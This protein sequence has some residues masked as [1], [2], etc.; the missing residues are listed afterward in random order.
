VNSQ[1]PTIQL[2][3][4]WG[5]ILALVVFCLPVEA[6]RTK[7]SRQA[8]H[9]IFLPLVQWPPLLPHSLYYINSGQIYRMERDGITITQ[10]TF[11]P[12]SVFD[13][14]ISPLTGKMA[15]SS[16]NQLI[17]ADADGVNR[18]V[19]VVS[20]TNVT[21]SPHWSPDGQTLVYQND[22]TMYFFDTET[23][24][25]TLV[26]GNDGDGNT[27]IPRDFSPN[28]SSLIVA[29]VPEQGPSR[30]GVYNIAS[31]TV[32]ILTPSEPPTHWPCCSPT[33]WSPDSSFIYISEFIG[34]GGPGGILYPGLWRYT[35]DG[36]G[37]PLLPLQDEDSSS[38]LN[39]TAAPWQEPDG[40]LMYLFSPPETGIDP[41]SP[42]SLVHTAPDGISNRVPLRPET[43]YITRLTLWTPDGSALVLVQSNGENTNIYE[44]MILIHMDSS[45]PVIT[46]LND[47]STLVGYM[48]LRW[49]P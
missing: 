25:S 20:D 34:A 18:Q 23:G 6:S 29:V 3:V 44:N 2:P 7:I 38:I 13:F 40:D 24:I 27:Y 14:D 30:L 32:S 46:L 19:L 48:S 37:I 15:Y 36:T 10:I 26:L 17:L 21:Y 9:N 4:L 35:T 22:G 39:K 11:E 28:G 1:K 5:L 42:F 49:G 47:A 31:E 33:Y 8:D 16:G 43:I 41:N 12:E 45:L